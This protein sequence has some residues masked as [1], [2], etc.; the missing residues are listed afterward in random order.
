MSFLKKFGFFAVIAMTVIGFSVC[1][2]D[3][4]EEKDTRLYID[5]ISFSRSSITNYG[6]DSITIEAKIYDPSSRAV[7]VFMT[8]SSLG[9]F[10]DIIFEKKSTKGN[11]VTFSSIIETPNVDPGEYAIEVSVEDNK[12][13]VD[14]KSRKLQVLGT[15]LPVINSITFVSAVTNGSNY[16]IKINS[17]DPDGDIDDVVVDFS[18]LG[19]SE[20]LSLPAVGGDEFETQVIP[21]S[22]VD[23]GNVVITVIDNLGATRVTNLEVMRYNPVVVYFI[24]GYGY[25][26]PQIHF[27]KEGSSGSSIS[28]KASAVEIG[29][30]EFE[31][32]E[33]FVNSVATYRFK[34]RD[35]SRW[36]DNI[37]VDSVQRGINVSAT[38]SPITNFAVSHNRT[39]FEDFASLD[40][41]VAVSGYNLSAPFGAEYVLPGAWKVGEGSYL[42]TVHSP[43][44]SRARITGEIVEPNWSASAAI[45]MKLDPYTGYWWV[46]ADA[47]VG[48]MYKFILSGSTWISDPYGRAFNSSDSMNAVIIDTDSY[49]WQSSFTRPPKDELVIY[50]MHVGDFTRTRDDVVDKGKYLGMI[51]K[52]DYLVALGVNAVELMPIQEW[53]GT[54]YSW[55]YN[56]CG[57]FAPESSYATDNTDGSAYDEFK[58]LVDA[59]HEAGIAVIIDVVYNH[60]ANNDNWLWDIDNDYYFD[61]EGTPWGNKVEFRNEM[62]QKFF[63]DNLKY[64]MDEF[65]IDGFRFDATEEI[66]L[67]SLIS[68]IEKLVDNG[69]DDRYYIFEHFA[70]P[71]GIRNFNNSQGSAA[72][73]SWGTGY[74]NTMWGALGGNTANNMGKPTYYHKDDGWNRPQEVIHYFS[75]HDEGTLVRH[76]GTNKQEV[77]LAATHLLTALGVPMIWMGD[78]FMRVHYGNYPP[79]GRGIDEANNVVDWSLTNDNADLIDYYKGLIK[80]R[81][82]NQALRMTHSDPANAGKF[83][84]RVT[85]TDWK[86]ANCTVQAGVIGYSLNDNGSEGDKKFV[87]VLNFGTAD[88]DGLIIH[89][90]ENGEW[91]V[92]S[93]GTQVEETGI[94]APVNVSGGTATYNIKAKHGYI[95]MK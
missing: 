49:T 41:K 87:V 12:K 89:F 93:D 62:V 60:T 80:L 42:F 82:E 63:L 76:V 74:K 28:S 23:S 88:R 83:A 78:E 16:T 6:G 25:N 35:G 90:P 11:I 57:F 77:K 29:G 13:V 18:E 56:N 75:S 37:S 21:V 51:E 85:P 40:E 17:S 27:W 59:L 65:R 4:E 94:G 44:Y 46:I 70:D 32:F 55:G 67:P 95:F 73:S 33:T 50:E 43:K 61:P 47:N 34:F 58:E 30:W 19:L 48:D 8:G 24:N 7:Q 81:I 20:N 1:G 91:L 38:S 3:D 9:Y 2:P 5:N 52:I 66:H 31:V 64:F 54:W 26:S 71:T 84:W 68:I 53:P 72:I 22:G 14:T 92:V 45:D 39:V 69:Y 36:E 10:S 15:M 86:Q 79:S